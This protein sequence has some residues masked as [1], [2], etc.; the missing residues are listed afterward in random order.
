MLRKIADADVVFFG[1][2]HNNPVAH[3]LQLEVT[4]DLYQEKNGNLV[5]G[6]EMFEADNQLI[7]DEYLEGTI[8]QKDFEKEARLWSNYG[9]R[10]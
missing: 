7:I 9:T 6:A 5:L 10:L 8:R 3:W 2:L 4:R 1:E